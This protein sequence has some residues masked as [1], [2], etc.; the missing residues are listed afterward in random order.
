MRLATLLFLALLLGELPVVVRA[1]EPQTTEFFEKRIRPLLVARCIDC[2]GADQSES[3]LRL[4]SRADM[5]EGGS[6]GAAI[7]PG[8]PDKSLL[9]RAVNHA[10]TL[11]MPPKEKLSQ[12]DINDLT[13]WVKAGA[14]W[15]DGDKPKPAAK[16]PAAKAAASVMQFTDEQKNF[17]AFQPMKHAAPPSV[18]LERWVQSP[19][20]RFILSEL[21]ARALQP[22]EV[23]D[24]RTLIR[25]ATFDL[26]GIPPTPDE[27][28]EFLADQEPDAFAR[29]IDR[30]LAS[31]RYGER[32]GRHWLDVARYG[33]SNGLD[34]N[35]AHA[36]AFRYRDW[37]ISAFN[38]DLPYDEFVREQIAGDLL[39]PEGDSND[40]G[41]AAQQNDRL[42]ATGFLVI[43]AKMLAEDDPLKMQ[44]DI[45][46]EQVDTIGKAFMGLTLGCARCHDHKYDPVSMA[47]YYSLAGIFKSTKTMNNFNVVA[48]WQERP[49][50]SPL[51]LQQFAEQKQRIA[52]KQADVN[53]LVAKANESLLDEARSRVADY[54]RAAARE[55]YLDKTSRSFGADYDKRADKSAPP[56]DGVQIL[57]AESYQRG[58]A[59]KLSTGYGE[60]IGVILSNGNGEWT[61]EYDVTVPAAGLYQ[62]EARYAAAD[63][64]PTQL[65]LNG[66]VIKQDALKDV[67]GSWNPDT[68]RWHVEGTYEFKAGVNVVRLFR[69]PPLPHID[70]L[71]IAKLLND[72][73]AGDVSPPVSGPT[74]DRSPTGGLTPPA[75][76]EVPL[77]PAF[78]GQWRRHL[79]KT[80]DDADTPFAEWRSQLM[81]LNDADS[82]KR[83]AIAPSLLPLADKISAE[84]AAVLVAWK[85]L[86]A[87]DAGKAATE[88]PDARQE[89]LR[90]LLFNTAEGSPFAVPKNAEEYFAAETKSALQTRRD[91]IKQLEMALPKLPEVMAVSEGTIDDL[92]IHLRGNHTTLAKDKQPR[93]FPRIL[94]GDQQA[95]L[96]TDRS[97]RLEFARWLTEPTHPLTARVAVNR[98]WQGHFG[99]G[100][101]RSP[102]NFGLLGD[103]PTHPV[104]LDWLATEFVGRISN[105]SASDAQARDGLENRPTNWSLK[106]LHRRIMLSSAYQMQTTFNEAAFLTDPDNRLWWRR[107]RRRLEVEAIR[108]SLLAVSG[109]LENSMGGSLLPTNNRAYV[110]GTANFF[111]QIYNSNRRSVY[112]PVVRSALYEVYQV[113]DFAEPSV[114][115]GKRDSTT[116]ATQA[117]FMLNSP[118]VSEQARE[119][120]QQV[121]SQ[122]DLDD[123]ARIRQAYQTCY[124]REPLSSET[125]R[126][127]NFLKELEAAQPETVPADR[128]RAAL[129]GLCR[130][131]LAANE[132]LFVE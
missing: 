124:Q 123:A 68:Q 96:A 109:K 113:F 1:E 51:V 74:S 13:A 115:N 82:A 45:V 76:Q 37:V 81:S 84:L 73:R 98:I 128:R 44:M 107:N 15:P 72:R 23:A 80:I 70:K 69:R 83:I 118:L 111:P 93:R 4:D 55:I 99:E 63:S 41:I 21:E 53:Q 28:A 48:Q 9:I 40:P 33:D 12:R 130:S 31:P 94:A 95:A 90:K 89:T 104:L 119:L 91:E 122:T 71:L 116:I 42:T 114:M 100:F 19:I 8:D 87:T 39:P 65:S 16:K 62:I 102:D 52:A 117:L 88:L 101:V 77:R 59:L 58:N 35:L 125:N 36:N 47:D 3:D 2:H 26:T 61:A 108:D 29:V 132:F 127:L 67:T 78:I 7:V 27:V 121:L 14:V 64:R 30:L 10:D 57:E 54:V 25:R 66:Q 11:A 97:G 105:P 49:L 110:T 5:L 129:R 34:E 18:K 103:K 106:R 75:R 92:P 46:D 131:L 43:G 56:P 79:E 22:A 60:G 24:K 126:S 120:A 85:E 50:A 6:R 17:W 38:R 112:L 32:W 86:K 20:D